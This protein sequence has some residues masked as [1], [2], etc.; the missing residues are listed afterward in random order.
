MTTWPQLLDRSAIR[1]RLEQIFPQGLT[2][3]NYV[4]REMAASTVFVMLY[5][6]A[7]E[8]NDYYV[9]PDQI[10]RMD[11]EQVARISDQERAAWRVASVR[12]G[13]K[14]GW[15][16]RNTREPIRDETLRQGLVHYGAAIE[17]T[18]LPTTSPRGRYALSESFAQLFAPQNTG[19]SL[20]RAI[21]DWRE[22]TL[23]ASAQARIRLLQ[24]AAV[25]THEGVLIEFPNSETR[26]LA[27]GPSSAIARA[28]I[29]DFAPRFLDRPGVLW[30]SES[31]QKES[32]RDAQLLSSLGIS[33]QTDRILPDIILVDLGV[34]L[35][36]PMFVFVECVATDGPITESR[37]EALLRIIKDAG[38]ETGQAAFVSAFLDRSHSAFK[39]SVAALAWSTFAWFVS[40]PDGLIGLH[41]NARTDYL[42]ALATGQSSANPSSSAQSVTPEPKVGG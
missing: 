17:L 39:R 1:N 35:K 24:R 25:A 5:L 30:V 40:E 3:R 23:S 2:N 9:R 29:E 4:I 11:D 41:E 28:V 32:Y 16:A 10:T 13:G 19:E 22:N 33:L 21:H 27:P 14:G 20:S 12:P 6:G 31:G 37:R 18:D 7:V 34:D 8:G 38:Y 42:S 26:R 15:Y 36:A